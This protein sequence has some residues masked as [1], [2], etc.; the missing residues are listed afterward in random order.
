[1]SDEPS[2]CQLDSLRLLFRALH[3]CR[4]ASP[5]TLNK[6]APGLQLLQGILATVQNR[7]AF[8]FS[9]EP[10]VLDEIGRTITKNPV[11]IPEDANSSG[12]G[13]SPAQRELLGCVRSLVAELARLAEGGN[14]QVVRDLGYQFHNL[15]SSLRDH[16]QCDGEAAMWFLRFAAGDWDELSV[17]MRDAFCKIARVDPHAAERLVRTNGFAEPRMDY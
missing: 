7:N 11:L 12:T 16:R 13:L 2:S 10:M 6:L 17:E 4:H 1:M 9:V 5:S 14:C 15:S 3:R 8:V